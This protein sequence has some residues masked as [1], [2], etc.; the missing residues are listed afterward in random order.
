MRPIRLRRKKTQAAARA[1][2]VA[3]LDDVG[4]GNQA[5]EYQVTSTPIDC[6]Y[7]NPQGYF[8]WLTFKMN[9]LSGAGADT[10]VG[11]GGV[12]CREWC[13]RGMRLTKGTQVDCAQSWQPRWLRE[14]H[15]PAPLLYCSV[16][17]GEFVC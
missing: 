16:S 1:E 14:S 10:G 3:T 6:S 9:E 11:T 17:G 12:W 5:W 4:D 13:W 2:A 7:E 8:D 15:E